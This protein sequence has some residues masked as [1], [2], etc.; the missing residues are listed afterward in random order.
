[1]NTHPIKTVSIFGAGALG[2]SY[3]G[4]LYDMDRE[5]V[6]FVAGGNRYEQLRR[7]C[8]IVNGVQYT[9]PVV[10]P[11]DQNT[12]GDDL[13]IVAVKY[14]HLPRTIEDMKNRIVENTIIISVMNGI[15]SEEQIGAA[16]GMERVLYAVSVGID[17]V[18]QENSVIYSTQ[19]KIYFGEPKNMI[20]SE[21][22]KR[23]KSFFDQAGIFYEIPEDMI[24]IVWW[25][26]MVNVGVNQASAA[27]NA[28]YGDIQTSP[29]ARSLMES[30][31]MEVIQIA[32]AEGIQLT[33]DDR[34]KWYQ[35][36]SGLSPSGKT[37]MLQ[38]VEAGRKTEVEMFAGK[39]LELGRKHAIPTPVNEKLFKTI[40]EIERH[41][42]K[43]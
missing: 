1:M 32:K 2:A 15:D 4:M 19:G 9:I 35:V 8:I 31:M 3:A 17:A 25:K 30:A 10:T 5:S 23:L 38:D 18:R 21:R 11:D 29:A 36:L 13:V 26:F 41:G 22:V 20:L 16:F 12:P 42:D 6:H 39:V 7:K 28:T 24:R 33:E 40:R 14:H 43:R 27:L 34:A 37:S